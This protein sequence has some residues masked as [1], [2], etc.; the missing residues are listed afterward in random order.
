MKASESGECDGRRWVPPPSSH[1]RAFM[2]IQPL[3]PTAAAVRSFGVYVSSAAPAAERGVRQPRR[4]EL[5]RVRG[6]DEKG[7]GGGTCGVEYPRALLGARRRPNGIG[8]RA[9]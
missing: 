8:A 4:R 3:Q 7:C 1:T 2:S 9:G 5:A 6:E